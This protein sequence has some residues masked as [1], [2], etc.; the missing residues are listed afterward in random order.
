MK[1]AIYDPYLDALGGGEKYMLT[2]AQCLSSENEVTILW[3]KKTDIEKNEERFNLDLS[4]VKIGKNIF[5]KNYPLT[6]KITESRKYD[7]IFY[8]SD[9]SI[10]VVFSKKLYV[11]FQFPVEWIK[12]DYKSKLKLK[13][14]NKIICNSSFTKEFIDK[15]LGVKSEVIY[16]PVEIKAQDIKKE[17]IILHVGRF[18][19]TE[20]E[21]QDYKKQYL[22]INAF[23]EMVDRGLKDWKFVIAASVR[24]HDLPDFQKMQAKAAGYPISFIVNATNND[25]WNSYNKAKI[26]WHASGYGENL[27]ERPELAEHFGISTVEA[28]GAGAVPIVINAGG[29]KEIVTDKV[30]GLLW[31][32]EEEL[33][34]KTKWLI[35]NPSELNKISSN[36]RAEA[37]KYSLNKFCTNLKNIII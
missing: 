13:R 12:L 8:L 5:A 11:H 35:K 33:I 23:K 4:K 28:M 21:N 9:G 31:N 19:L 3:D 2:A 26:Y 6:K 27:Q 34:E 18:M 37:E 14:V 22:M 17:N 7:A 30:N 16:P 20:K 1:I 15:K 25:L 32:T 10:P 36:G 29:Q 24:S